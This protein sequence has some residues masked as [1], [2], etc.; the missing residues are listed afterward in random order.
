MERALREGHHQGGGSTFLDP[1]VEPIY[2]EEREKRKGETSGR[3]IW[4]GKRKQ[5]LDT[6]TTLMIRLDENLY[7][8]EI[9]SFYY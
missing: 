5:K 7:V 8:A 6:D 2:H 9:L 1:N 4:R 3:W